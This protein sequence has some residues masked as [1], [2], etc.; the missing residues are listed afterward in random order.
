M[1]SYNT[2]PQ[3]WVQDVVV[4]VIGI[5]M[6]ISLFIGRALT[7]DN[8]IK[9]SLYPAPPKL[10]SE[11]PLKNPAMPAP[12]LSVQVFFHFR[13]KLPSNQNGLL[14]TISNNIEV[15]EEPVPLTKKI[16]HCTV[17]FEA[18]DQNCLH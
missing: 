17:K 8:Y 9:C 16:P 5:C 4:I 1:N 3:V 15:Y 10:K 13:Q 6:K 7:S 2:A 11:Y 18:S 14:C 12:L